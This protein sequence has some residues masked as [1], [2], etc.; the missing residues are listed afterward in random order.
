MQVDTRHTTQSLLEAKAIYHRQGCSAKVTTIY[1][2]HDNTVFTKIRTQAK[3]T[4]GQGRH[5]C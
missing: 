5:S 2:N 1:E 3:L 4:F